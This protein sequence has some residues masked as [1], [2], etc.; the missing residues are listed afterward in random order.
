MPEPIKPEPIKPEPIKPETP[1]LKMNWPIDRLDKHPVVTLAAGYVLRQFK[2][3]DKSAF[4]QLMRNCGWDDWGETQFDFCRS[5]VLPHGWFVVEN[6][7]S[8]QLVASAQS[9][10]NYT[11]QSPQSGTLG[12]VGC[13][14]QHRGHRL[15]SAV[16]AAATARLLAGGYEDVELYTE[17]FRLPALRTYLTLGYVPYL[18]SD[19]VTEV[20]RDV[21]NQLDWPFAPG[22]WPSGNNAFPST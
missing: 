12:W 9:L 3:A 14:P 15:G 4:I 10:H 8:G 5:K 7:S 22:D 1:Q 16:T 17:H 21:C 19:A 2:P 18:Y 20:W 6:S 11:D 13:S